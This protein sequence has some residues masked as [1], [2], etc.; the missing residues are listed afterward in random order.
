MSIRLNKHHKETIA[1]NARK[2]SPLNAQ[3]DQVFKARKVLAESIRVE[4]LGGLKKTKEYDDIAKD[5]LLQRDKLPYN[6]LSHST[7]INMA[8][9]MYVGLS[10]TE[11]RYCLNFEDIRVA[12][13][14]TRDLTTGSRYYD[15]LI[16]SIEIE[17]KIREELIE[18]EQ[19]V[20]ASI[21]GITT[22][23]KLLETWPE[24]V[25]LLPSD[26]TQQPVRLPALRTD[27]L[28]KLIGLP[29]KKASGT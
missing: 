8:S 22:L 23:K 12:I 13:K 3:L 21:S 18:L 1:Q 20:Y 7:G 28:N 26:I 19:S 14:G 11:R 6:L 15:P 24:V 5:R 4:S 25:E 17:D 9:R 27:N 29:T 10:K 2:L 16:K